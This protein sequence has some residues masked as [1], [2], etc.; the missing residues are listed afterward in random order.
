MFVSALF[1]IIQYGKPTKQSSNGEWI[2]S[3]AILWN[4]THKKNIKLLKSG[5]IWINFKIIMQGFKRH[6]KQMYNS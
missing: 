6:M 5:T 1:A 2:S 4:I 3:L